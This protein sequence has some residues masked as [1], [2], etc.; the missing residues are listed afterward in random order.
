MKWI[1]IDKAKVKFDTK[2][3]ICTSNRE[4]VTGNL[5]KSET[6]PSGVRHKFETFTDGQEVNDA[7]H[8]AIITDPQ[9]DEAAKLVG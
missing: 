2:Y 5:T 8:V 9:A 1:P 4:F 3:L 6:T 7:T